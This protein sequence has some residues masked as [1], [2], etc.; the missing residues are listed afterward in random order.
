M[1]DSNP[2]HSF[3]QSL[4]CV[5]DVD[6]LRAF[7]GFDSDASVELRKWFH[8]WTCGKRLQLVHGVIAQFSCLF[9]SFGRRA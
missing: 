4:S 5:S 9:R 1:R 6:V 3:V 7:G 2:G 8:L